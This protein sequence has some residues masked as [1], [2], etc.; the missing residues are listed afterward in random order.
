VKISELKKGVDKGSQK[1]ATHPT[2]TDDPD[3]YIGKW[4]AYDE[5]QGIGSPAGKEVTKNTSVLGKK[6]KTEATQPFGDIPSRGGVSSGTWQHFPTSD[7]I[8]PNSPSA[9]PRKRSPMKNNR[10]PLKATKRKVRKLNTNSVREGL[11]FEYI[12][13]PQQND[14]TADYEVRDDVGEELLG[15][16]RVTGGVIELLSAKDT[17][18]EDYSGH[19]YAQL[20]GTIIRDADDSNANLSILLARENDLNFM[21]FMERFGF[22]HIGEGIMKRNAGAIKPPGVP[23]GSNGIF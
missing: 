3:K 17:L 1:R 21:R 6:K 14:F 8:N 13:K 15:F 9:N 11:I 22:R 12:R 2:A 23:M 5:P 19:V 18:K 16:A 4:E 7:D 10:A 20:V